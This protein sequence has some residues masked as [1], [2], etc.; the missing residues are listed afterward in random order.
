MKRVEYIGG[1]GLAGYVLRVNDG[2]VKV[3]D[4]LELPDA[5]ADA[6]LATGLWKPADSPKP[7]AKAKKR[8]KK[9]G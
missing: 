6:L 5:D 3:G 8:T 4:V 7:K 2:P 1:E 9:K